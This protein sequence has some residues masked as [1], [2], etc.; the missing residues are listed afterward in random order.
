[1][2]RDGYISAQEVRRLQKAGAVGET[3]GW[4][5]NAS[6]ELIELPGYHD[7]LTSIPPQRRSKSP[8]IAFAGGKDKWDCVR[9]ALRGKWISGLVTDESC[10][11]AIV[12]SEA[13]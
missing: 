5:L 2:Q 13:I 1:M 7:K 12:K 3:S 9:A 6:G 10:A 11:Q 8:V 4:V